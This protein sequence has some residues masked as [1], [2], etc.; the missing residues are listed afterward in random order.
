MKLQVCNT[1]VTV[2]ENIWEI[3]IIEIVSVLYLCPPRPT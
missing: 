1:A 3:R 2:E